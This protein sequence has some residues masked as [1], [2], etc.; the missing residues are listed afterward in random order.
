MR[1]MPRSFVLF[2]AVCMFSVAGF[3]DFERDVEREAASAICV[4]ADSGLVIYEYNADEVRAPASMVKMMLMLMV[5]EG[6]EAKRWTLE[7]PITITAKTQSMG[8][9]QVYLEAGEKWKVG[10]LMAAVCVASGNDAAMGLA[11][12]L[13]GTEEKYLAAMNKRA[14]EL[15]MAS[16]TFRSVHGL[17]PSPGEKPDETTARDMAVLAIKCSQ[18]PTI[19][20][21]VGQKELR[22]RKKDAIKYSTNKLLW[23]MDE[24]DGLKTGFTSAAGWCLAATAQKDGVRV[25]SVVMGCRSKNGRF[26]ISEKN[27]RKGF[28][29][30]ERVC[31]FAKGKRVE[32]SVSVENCRT[33]RFN[34]VADRDVWITV[35]K[36]Y[37]SQLRISADIPQTLHPPLKAGTVIGEG[38]VTIDGVELGVSPLILA[39]DLTPA[40]VR[41]KMVQAVMGAVKSPADYVSEE[42]L[43]SGPLDSQ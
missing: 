26:D 31:L 28:E 22:F 17:P 37:K 4:V 19:M 9:A 14:K 24:C 18:Q 20:K 3:A 36:K 6:L 29:N 30:T 38:R 21:W 16:S 15:G 27:L 7:D 33:E 43:T 8:G 42:S 1:M 11:E 25:V 13:W 39:E 5:S 32:N 35:P 10:D 41:W 23:R 2:F 12:G 34:P 40:S